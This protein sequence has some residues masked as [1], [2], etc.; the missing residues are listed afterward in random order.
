LTIA[1]ELA[2]SATLIQEL[3]QAASV[4]RWVTAARPRRKRAMAAHSESVRRDALVQRDARAAPPELGLAGF[5]LTDA[6]LVAEIIGDLAHV[7]RK[8]SSWRCARDRT[9]A[10]PRERCVEWRRHRLRRVPL[11]GREHLVREGTACIRRVTRVAR[12]ASPD[13]R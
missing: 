2:G 3:V 4:R 7:E 8:R 5:A 6:A 10:V 11:H 9:R 1:P 13:P 12:R